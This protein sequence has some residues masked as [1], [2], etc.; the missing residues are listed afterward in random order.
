MA[1]A[2]REM[3]IYLRAEAPKRVGAIQETTL[4]KLARILREGI[5]GGQDNE[6]IADQIEAVYDDQFIPN[7]AE[8]I[9]GNEV[10]QISNYGSQQG[11]KATGLELKKY[12]ITQRDNRVRGAS[13]PG[14]LY[15]NSPYDHYAA[16]H[17]A[18]DLEEPFEVS[19]E[20]MDFPGDESKGASLGNTIN[21][22]CF[23]AYD[24][25]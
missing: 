2:V 7:R 19:G 15:Q 9:A 24:D 16:D 14:G 12:W 18:K 3:R 1:L 17:Q 13:N 4:D 25:I 8:T 21:C 10:V 5:L 22:R 20:Q 23:L 11:A 6:K